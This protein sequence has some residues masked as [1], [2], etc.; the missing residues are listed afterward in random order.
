MREMLANKY[1]LNGQAAKAMELYEQALADE[2]DQADLQCR[3]ILAQ[4]AQA[5]DERTAPL[6]EVAAFIST[7]MDRGGREALTKL[8]EG[9]QGYAKHADHPGEGAALNGLKALLAG[10][11]EQ[12]LLLL[13][14]VDPTKQPAVAALKNRLSNQQTKKAIGGAS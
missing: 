2:P 9:C 13:S 11:D 5:S 14:T 10:R 12:A 7:I 6:E 4:L 3:L 1:L 8:V